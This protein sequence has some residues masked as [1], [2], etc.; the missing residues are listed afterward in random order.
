MRAVVFLGPS[1]PVAEAARRLDAIYLPPARQADVLSA[2]TRYHPDAIGIVDGEFGQSLSV[3][4]KEI[5]YALEQGVQVFGAS[6]MGALRA[7]ETDCFGTIGVG[8]I[9]RMYASGE[10]TDDDEVA[11]AHGHDE[12]GYVNL[13]EPLVNIRAT[14]ADAREAGIV[15]AALHDQLVAIAKGTFF[16]ERSYAGLLAAAAERGVAPG[17]LAGLRDF[18]AAHRRDLK[19]EDAL[20]LLDA[21]RDFAGAP[22]P[23]RPDF[24]LSRTGYFEGLYHRD[25]QVYHG[26]APVSLAGVA[27]H[28]ALHTAGFNALNFA[29]LNRALVTV[30]ADMLDV[31]VTDE[32]RAAESRRFRLERQLTD[33]T[34]FADWLARNDLERAEFEALMAELAVCRSLHRWLI[35]RKWPEYSTKFVLDELRLAGRYPATARAAAAQERV[36]AEQHPFFRETDFSHVPMR[37]LVVDHMRATPCRMYDYDAWAEEAGFPKSSDL[38]LDLLRSR[39]AREAMARTAGELAHALVDRPASE[40]PTPAAT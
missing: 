23:S 8:R 6:S 40:A 27:S 25:R 16:P 32:A 13:S 28:A 9:Y 5:L 14:L 22:R 20:A 2:M 11:L 36:L 17:V 29:A 19:R 30:L 3:W 10:L 35:L 34:T 15:D 1:L 7:A 33:E 4:H 39:L 31:E 26:D 12:H 18:V 21:L 38:R 24:V 37:D